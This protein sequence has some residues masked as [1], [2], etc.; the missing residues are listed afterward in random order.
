MASA[1]SAKKEG[2][3]KAA[4]S[5]ILMSQGRPGLSIFRKSGHRFSVENA[6]KSKI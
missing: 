6:I 3:P 1:A 2:R 5:V 4:F